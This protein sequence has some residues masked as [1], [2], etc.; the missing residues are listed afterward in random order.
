MT[1]IRVPDVFDAEGHT[2]VDVQRR[3]MGRLMRRFPR[4]DACVREDAVSFAMVDL[5]SYWQDLASS[6]DA[7]TGKLTFN[8]AVQRG[9]WKAIEFVLAELRRTDSEAWMND[10]S[11]RDPRYGGLD[12]IDG[13][14]FEEAQAALESQFPDPS[15]GP[16]ELVIEADEEQRVREL[17]ATMSAE[18]LAECFVLFE[19][20]SQ[21]ELAEKLGVSQSTAYRRQRDAKVKVKDRARKFGFVPAA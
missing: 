1:D 2:W 5:I 20:G 21:R 3:L 13:D 9:V 12:H 16:E 19:E 10:Y 18:E 7:D 17:L 8:F 15:P 4:V 11:L 6:T 14:D